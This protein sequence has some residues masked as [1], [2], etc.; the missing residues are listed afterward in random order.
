MSFKHVPPHPVLA[1]ALIIEADVAR[2]IAQGVFDVAPFLRRHLANDWGNLTDAERR[3][4]KRVQVQGGEFFS[5]YRVSASHTLWILSE[6]NRSITTLTL[7]PPALPPSPD[8][9]QISDEIVF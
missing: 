1:G 8:D 5:S 2:L 3:E 7:P 9:G 6:W 4:N